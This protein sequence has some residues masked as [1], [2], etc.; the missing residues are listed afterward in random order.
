MVQNNLTFNDLPQV[1]A[2]L[3]GEVSTLKNLIE[4]IRDTSQHPEPDELMNIKQAGEFLHLTVQTIYNKVSKNEIPFMKRGKRLY[5]SK[6]ELMNYL[7]QGSN[8]M[9]SDIDKDVNDF[10]SKKKGVKL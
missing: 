5:F 1:V 2:Q 6:D 10:L 8:E 4:E 3:V 7:K 9:Q